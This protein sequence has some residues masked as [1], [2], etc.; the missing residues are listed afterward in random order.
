MSLRR[1]RYVTLCIR[2]FKY[3]NELN[4]RKRRNVWPKC[5]NRIAWF[6]FG[7]SC[8]FETILLNCLFVFFL[9]HI[10]KMPPTSKSWCAYPYHEIIDS[11]TG[12]KKLVKTGKN[13]THQVGIHRID[14]DTASNISTNYALTMKS[15]PKTFLKLTRYVPVV[16]DG[17]LIM[18]EMGIKLIWMKFNL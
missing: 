17:Y 11:V 7:R 2:I 8:H 10:V 14:A 4:A 16:W 9:L 12:R 5:T 18:K 6:D 13:L 1:V 3:T 15:G